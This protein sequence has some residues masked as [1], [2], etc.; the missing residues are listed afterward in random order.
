MRR[1]KEAIIWF[2][3]KREVPLCLSL[4]YVFTG[5]RTI[6]VDIINGKQTKRKEKFDYHI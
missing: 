4:E 3:Y 2:P 5:K 1:D 6:G